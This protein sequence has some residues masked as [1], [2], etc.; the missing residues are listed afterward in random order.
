MTFFVKDPITGKAVA[1]K[2][3]NLFR[4]GSEYRFVPNDIYGTENDHLSRVVDRLLEEYGIPVH[5]EEGVPSWAKP[6][7][8]RHSIRDFYSD[9]HA[10]KMKFRRWKG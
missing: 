4:F 6:A 1:H 3:Y 8:S 10:R 5:H 9:V 7:E 2:T